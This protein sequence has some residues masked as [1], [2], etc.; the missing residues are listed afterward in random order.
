ME[1]YHL[2]YPGSLASL[3]LSNLPCGTWSTGYFDESELA[4]LLTKCSF[5][6]IETLPILFSLSNGMEI[7]E[8]N[9]QQLA[10]EMEQR[11]GK[12][13]PRWVRS[14]LACLFFPPTTLCFGL[15][16]T[17]LILFFNIL[18]LKRVA[19]RRYWHWQRWSSK[20]PMPVLPVGER[21]IDA[22]QCRAG[23]WSGGGA[24]VVAGVDYGES[25]VDTVNVPG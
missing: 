6:K 19:A 5:L 4:H 1:V 18:I 23:Y 13:L 14:L 21:V 3:S 25:R 10:K 20:A 9:S 11:R 2:R 7:A 22:R 12:R 17:N 8:R 15:L 24:V 16:C